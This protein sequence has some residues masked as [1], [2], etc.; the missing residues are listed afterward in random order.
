MRRTRGF[1]L[2]ELLVVIAIIAL[3]ASI[4]VPTLVK[5]RE[6]AKRTICLANLNGIGKAIVLD[7]SNNNDEFPYIFGGDPI[8]PTDWNVALQAV[9][10][11][12]LAVDAN[13]PNAYGMSSDNAT[14]SSNPVE[15]LNKLVYFNY[16]DWKVFRC[17]SVSGEVAQRIPSSS[18]YG[19][20]VVSNGT[21]GI[22]VDYAIHPTRTYLKNA[23]HAAPAGFVNAAPLSDNLEGE[24][25]FL[26]DQVT[27]GDPNVQYTSGKVKG[28]SDKSNHKTDGINV[29][30]VSWS[31]RWMQSS[32]GEGVAPRIFV[33]NLDPNG[34]NDT[35][36]GDPN[37]GWNVEVPKYRTDSVCV[38]AW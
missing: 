19:F 30:Y 24:F 12:K 21:I 3:L 27:L 25:G 10:P 15:T 4:L 2:I 26:C 38:G 33:Q 18:A 16:V 6:I 36:S 17:P 9:G 8:Q 22:F 7:K 5:A 37:T 14:K 11:G 20:K 29:L 23:A 1:T 34:S 35:G 32:S 31:S 28:L 13:A